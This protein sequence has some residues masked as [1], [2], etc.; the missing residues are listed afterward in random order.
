MDV[1]HLDAHRILPESPFTFKCGN[2]GALST[3]SAS[4]LEI[5]ILTVTSCSNFLHHCIFSH[6]I[7]NPAILPSLYT[8]SPHS[9]AL[10]FLFYP[11][12]SAPKTGKVRS[13]ENTELKTESVP[14]GK[15][16]EELGYRLNKMSSLTRESRQGDEN[17][18]QLYKELNK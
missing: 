3:F 14:K 2:P 4:S 17:Q 10:P 15:Q 16:A 18:V 7:L 13:E 5:Y 8:F 1:C 12:L 6:L 11:S 9:V